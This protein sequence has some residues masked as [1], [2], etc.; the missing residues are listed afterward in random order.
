MFLGEVDAYEDK[1]DV[2][3][4]GA[5]F[6]MKAGA[7]LNGSQPGRHAKC[8]GCWCIYF[9]SWFFALQELIKAQ[10]RQPE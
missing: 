10:E 4:L 1:H 5:R 6:R 7:Q 9:H 2:S 8:L 3:N